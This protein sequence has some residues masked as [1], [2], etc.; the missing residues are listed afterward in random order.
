MAAPPQVTWQAGRP[1]PPWHTPPLSAPPPSTHWLQGSSGGAASRW[2]RM[3]RSYNPRWKAAPPRRK[4]RK[5]VSRGDEG[6]GGLRGE[7]TGRG[8]GPQTLI[9]MAWMTLAGLLSFVAEAC[10]GSR[11]RSCTCIVSASWIREVGPPPPLQCPF[12]PPHSLLHTWKTIE[13]P[14]RST[15]TGQT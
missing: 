2:G 9:K 11:W 8:C 1:P 5:A 10:R 14:T 15:Q 4:R 3:R 12:T 13:T 6:G 7:G